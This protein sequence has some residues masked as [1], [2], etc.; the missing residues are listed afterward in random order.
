[1][2]FGGIWLVIVNSFRLLFAIKYSKFVVQI[3]TFDCNDDTL[4]QSLAVTFKQNKCIKPTEKKRQ[5]KNKPKTNKIYDRK[6]Q[7]RGKVRSFMYICVWY[8]PVCYSF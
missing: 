6:E 5:K 1:M 7:K 8:I 3:K 2:V 4:T